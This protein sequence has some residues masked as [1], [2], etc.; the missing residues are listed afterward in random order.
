[1]KVVI[2]D[3]KGRFIALNVI[4]KAIDLRKIFIRYF[5]KQVI[6]RLNMIGFWK[7]KLSFFELNIL[8]L[9][10]LYPFDEDLREVYLL[11]HFYSFV[12]PFC[13]LK[14]FNST[15]LYLICYEIKRIYST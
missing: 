4:M 8:W 7:F 2:E 10:D 6:E 5:L 15:L 13:F 1:M 9:I 11:F 3:E 14:M 12:L